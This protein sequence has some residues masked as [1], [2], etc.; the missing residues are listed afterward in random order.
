VQQ[1]QEELDEDDNRNQH[2]APDQLRPARAFRIK[3]DLE[4]RNKRNV[5]Q[6]SNHA[7]RNRSTNNKAPGNRGKRREH[8]QPDALKKVP[9]FAIVR[10]TVN[11]LTP[12]E[13]PEYA[14]PPAGI[15][16][17]HT[18]SMPGLRQDR[19]AR[20]MMSFSHHGVLASQTIRRRDNSTRII[21]FGLHH[22][23]I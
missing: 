16:P 22:G 18:R 2:T 11:F 1:P 7:R 4:K 20:E 8:P 19:C 5:K 6:N 17:S 12:D 14:K 21:E 10:K 13:L 3:E 9:P 23:R 15:R